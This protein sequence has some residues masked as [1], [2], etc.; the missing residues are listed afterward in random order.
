MIIYLENP[1]E[2]IGKPIKIIE[3]SKVTSYTIH[4]KSFVYIYIHIY[5]KNN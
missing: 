2:S 4:T 1:E 5:M 3:F